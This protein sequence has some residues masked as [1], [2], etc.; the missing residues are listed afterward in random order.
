MIFSLDWIVD[1]CWGSSGFLFLHSWIKLLQLATANEKRKICPRNHMK[2]LTIE[3][4][5]IT[6]KVDKWKMLVSTDPVAP[7]ELPP[8]KT[9]LLRLRKAKN[10]KVETNEFAGKCDATSGKKNRGGCY[11]LKASCQSALSNDASLSQTQNTATR[12]R[13]LGIKLEF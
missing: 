11:H 6:W 3:K 9:L 10:G 12:Q 4:R 5:G 8:V 1:F 2:G 7:P 13:F